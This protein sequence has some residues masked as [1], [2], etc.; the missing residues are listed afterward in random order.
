M[1][2]K[3]S[4]IDTV[5]NQINEIIDQSIN[6]ALLMH[7]GSITLEDIELC[8]DSW[9]VYIKFHGGCIGCPSATSQTLTMVEM[10]LREEMD[11]PGLSVRNIDSH[12]VYAK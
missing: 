1:K 7:S 3:L 5:K 8:G 6:P 10:C 12:R 11:A 4:S 2:N 9:C